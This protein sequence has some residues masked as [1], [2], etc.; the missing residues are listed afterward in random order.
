MRGKVIGWAL[1]D[2]NDAGQGAA[3]LGATATQ[4]TTILLLKL[5]H[6]LRRRIAAD[7]ILMM[8]ALEEFYWTTFQRECQKLQMTRETVKDRSCKWQLTIMMQEAGASNTCVKALVFQAPN[9]APFEAQ[10]KRQS[11]LFEI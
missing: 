7:R 6:Y 11:L 4:H 5:L 2:T 8:Q 10:Y 1:T 3:P 9:E